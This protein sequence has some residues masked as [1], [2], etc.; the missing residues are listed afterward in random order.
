MN[1]DSH[2]HPDPDFSPSI[3]QTP[4]PDKVP[5]PNTMPPPKTPD[6]DELPVPPVFPTA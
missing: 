4:I 5:E 3:P 1:K 6:D 2:T